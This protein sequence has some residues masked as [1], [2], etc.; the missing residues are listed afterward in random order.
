MSNLSVLG[1]TKTRI[2]KRL[3][4]Q[5]QTAIDLASLLRMQV[6]AA[7]KHLDRLEQLGFIHQEYRQAGL[8]RPKKFYHIT[9]QGNELFPRL[10]DRV[11]NATISKT[12]RNQGSEKAESI[13][14]E[15][16]SDIAATVDLDLDKI[17]NLT[18]TLNELGFEA[19][20]TKTPHSYAIISRNCPLL[21]TAKVHKEVVCRGLHE[22]IYKEVLGTTELRREKWI[23]NNDPIC[24]HIVPRD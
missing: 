16:A 11:L 5:G 14:K 12:I 7:R 22:E 18:R 21:S 24:K 6:S 2:L 3:R 23:V 4:E 9:E 10:Y 1:P 19:S 13:M 20:I 8:G 17:G 15:I